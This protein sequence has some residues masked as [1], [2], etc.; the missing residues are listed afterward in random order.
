MSAEIQMGNL[1]KELMKGRKLMSSFLALA[2][3]DVVKLSPAIR[4]NESGRSLPDDWR[5]LREGRR[6]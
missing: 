5:M 6:I 2:V 4:R 1:L 3:S